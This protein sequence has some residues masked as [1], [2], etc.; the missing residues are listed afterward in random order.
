MQRPS[1]QCRARPRPSSRI[2]SLKPDIRLLQLHPRQPGSKFI[3]KLTSQNFCESQLDQSTVWQHVRMS[4][5]P[6]KVASAAGKADTPPDATLRGSTRATCCRT[7]GSGWWRRRAVAGCFSAHH[8]ST[9]QRVNHQWA[10]VRRDSRQPS[11]PAD[12]CA[13]KEDANATLVDPVSLAGRLAVALGGSG[14]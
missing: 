6:L 10:G 13:M 11:C 5:H 1:G 9:P 8:P 12:S 4:G 14:R 2:E 3:S 7:N